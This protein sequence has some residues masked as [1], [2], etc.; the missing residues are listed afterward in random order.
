MSIVYQT[1]LQYRFDFFWIVIVRIR[2]VSIRSCTGSTFLD[3]DCMDSN[4][5]DPDLCR[6]DFFGLEL[7]GLDFYQSPLYRFDFLDW[8]CM[9]SVFVAPVVYRRDIY[10]FYRPGHVPIWAE[11][12]VWRWSAGALGR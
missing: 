7:Y 12:G 10:R 8:D 6:L 9:D 4:C 1:F 2:I 3:W 5:I 11:G